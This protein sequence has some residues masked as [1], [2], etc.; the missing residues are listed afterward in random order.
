MTETAANDPQAL[1][2][3]ISA[4]E[5][6]K[7]IPAA[8]ELDCGRLA[9]AVETRRRADLL[10]ARLQDDRWIQQM[11]DQQGGASVD[12]R[13]LKGITA[14]LKLI[15]SDDTTGLPGCELLE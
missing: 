6:V 2:D 8:P 5:P 12:S 7:S 11:C 3:G 9:A 14:V 4:A 10:L 13:L 15:T 1:Q